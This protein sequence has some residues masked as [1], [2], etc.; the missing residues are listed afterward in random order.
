M[1]CGIAVHEL[2]RVDRPAELPLCARAA[3]RAL[4][5]GYRGGGEEGGGLACAPSLWAGPGSVELYRTYDAQRISEVIQEER[6]KLL[7]QVLLLLAL[8]VQKSA[9]TDAGGAGNAEGVGG[10]VGRVALQL[11]E[12]VALQLAAAAAAAT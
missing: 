9:S 6:E 5:I 1:L 12:R 8:L 2:A 10:V 3:Q 4:Q 7:Q 11:A